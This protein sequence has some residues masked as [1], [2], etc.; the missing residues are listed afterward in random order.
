[1]KI[2]NVFTNIVGRTKFVVTLTGEQW[3]TQYKAVVDNLLDELT[4]GE[5][6]EYLAQIGHFVV[7][8]RG[9]DA[10]VDEFYRRNWPPA[11]HP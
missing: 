5:P 10:H 6:F 11:C 7:H 4:G 3:R 1:M 2:H 9:N 8:Y